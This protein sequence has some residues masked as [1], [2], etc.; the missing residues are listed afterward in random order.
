MKKLILVST[1]VMLA[2]TVQAQIYTMLDFTGFLYESDNTPGVQGYPPSN[3]GDVL[4]GV[5]FVESIG[6]E[7]SDDP[8]WDLNEF[9]ITWVLSNLI[10]YG[11]TDLGSGLYQIFYTG[12]TFDI[13]GDRY[14]RPNH[15]A[16]VYGIEPPNAT[17][18]A[19]FWDSR[20]YLHGEL[21]DFF[22]I[23]DTNLNTG[24][25]ESRMIFTSGTELSDLVHNPEG[26]TVA[27][28]VNQGS[29]P[30]PDGYDLEAIGHITFDALIPASKSTWGQ[31][32]NLF[33]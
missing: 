33:R 3:P 4:S 9:E 31:V 15:S 28:T 22:M 6:T 18:P 26:F 8:D 10:S 13:V 21:T 16:S 12:G 32:K 17:A 25:Y 11:E 30:I 20:I 24:Y 1:C 14:T 2:G 7:L 19:T 29:A 27:G 5:G 23:C